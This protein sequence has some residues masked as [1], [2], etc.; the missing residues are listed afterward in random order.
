MWFGVDAVTA[1][2]KRV[3]KSVAA[4]CEDMKNS[5]PYPRGM[6][7]MQLQ[8]A[9]RKNGRMVKLKLQIVSP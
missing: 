3:E 1:I 4:S 7:R 9:A 5:A 6:P 8:E 2:M